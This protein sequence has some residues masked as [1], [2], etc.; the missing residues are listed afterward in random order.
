MNLSLAPLQGFTDAIFRNVFTD[1]FGHVDTYYAPYI[2]FQNDGSIRNSQWRDITPGRNETRAIP[3]ILVA[4]A[5][6]ALGLTQRIV[7]LETYKDVNINLGCPFP[8]VT[9]R[10]R[11][12]A[13][14]KNLDELERVLDALF[15]TYGDQLNFS[16]KMRCGMTEFD[17]VSKAIEVLNNYKISHT[18]LH[19]RVAKQLYKGKA[20]QDAFGEVLS[21]INHPLHYNGDIRT[22][23][24]Y[25][26]LLE[27][28]P[29]IEGVMIGRG[30]LENP[31][32]PQE[33]KTGERVEDAKRLVLFSEFHQALYDTNETHLSGDSHLLNKMKSYL[34]YFEQFAP[35]NKKAYK[36]VK[37][38]NGL[39]SYAEGMQGLFNV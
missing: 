15:S 22:V 19:P 30:I 29:S 2:A 33:I 24:H 38:C 28:F 35:V 8:M 1:C 27:R 25:N 31:L 6:E 34:P 7:E 21:Q 9:N 26:E 16:V 12:S 11:G 5:E 14:L 10:G 23:K 17:E 39:R 36:K 3:Q 20:N 4:N 32:L 13:L 18:I 37:K